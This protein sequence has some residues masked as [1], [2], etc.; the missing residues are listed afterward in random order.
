MLR[1]WPPPRCPP[2]P[3]LR[4]RPRRRAASSRSGPRARRGAGGGPASASASA[5]RAHPPESPPP[6]APAPRA[7]PSRSARRPPCTLRGPGLP[8]ASPPPSSSSVPRAGPRRALS[9]ASPAAPGRS[10]LQGA[11]FTARTSASAS[12]AGEARRPGRGVQE[13]EPAGPGTPRPRRPDLRGLLAERRARAGREVGAPPPG[14][15]PSCEDAA[16]RSHGGVCAGGRSR[17]A[18]SASARPR[19]LLCGAGRAARRARAPSRRPARR[20]PPLPPHTHL[21]RVPSAAPLPEP[22]PAYSPGA[23]HALRGPT[24]GG[25]VRAGARARS[26]AQRS[27]PALCGARPPA[28]GPGDLLD[29]VPR[30]KSQSLCEAVIFFFT[31]TELGEWPECLFHSVLEEPCRALRSPHSTHAPVGLGKGT[32]PPIAK[33]AETL[34]ICAKRARLS[35]LVRR[36]RSNQRR[37][38]YTVSEGLKDKPTFTGSTYFR[39]LPPKKNTPFFLH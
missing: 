27:R 32:G 39:P 33:G 2:A 37:S 17:A 29:R 10:A 7:H 20:T 26:G 28:S 34:Q 16:R 35:S 1:S 6:S 14:K 24:R 18:S 31:L 21:P 4:A 5:P 36:S 38:Q 25:D 22:A 19:T 13:R 8:G 9:P 23:A 12:S 3:P 11:M 15:F 30:A